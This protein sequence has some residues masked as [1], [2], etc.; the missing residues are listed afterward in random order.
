M[1]MNNRFSGSF[2][3]AADQEKSIPK[4]GVIDGVSLMGKQLAAGIAL[5]LVA[6][7]GHAVDTGRFDGASAA[8][9]TH[10]VS[11]TVGTAG[12]G[13]TTDPSRL[14]LADKTV[15]YTAAADNELL[16][17]SRNNSDAPAIKTPGMG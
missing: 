8:T 3:H 17:V 15:I 1:T 13:A 10:A 2:G 7:I 16:F 5:S 4:A 6:A 9:Q 11:L 12:G 14:A